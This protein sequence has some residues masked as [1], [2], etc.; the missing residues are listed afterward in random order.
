[1]VQSQHRPKLQDWSQQE[2]LNLRRRQP[3]H[4]KLPNYPNWASNFPRPKLLFS[5]INFRKKWLHPRKMQNVQGVQ[6]E[7]YCQTSVLSIVANKDTKAKPVLI[8]LII[9]F[10]SQNFTFVNDR[11]IYGAPEFRCQFY[12]PIFLCQS[13]F[14]L[15]VPFL[16]VNSQFSLS[17]YAFFSLSIW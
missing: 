10:N 8:S 2:S 14:S 6:D 13:H 1:M 9:F 15:S 17:E 4:K 3:T 5:T 16:S 11:G 7:F 12:F